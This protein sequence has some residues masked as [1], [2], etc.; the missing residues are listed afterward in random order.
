MALPVL[1]RQIFRITLALFDHKKGGSTVKRLNI[2]VGKGIAV[3]AVMALFVFG[4]GLDATAKQY[5]RLYTGVRPLG[6]GDAF[7]AVADDEN[8]LFYNPAGLSRLSTVQIGLINPLVEVSKKTIDLVQ[9][10]QD[11]DM[12]DTGEVADLLKEYVGEHQHARVGLFPHVGFNVAGAGVMIGGIGQGTLDVDVR[13]PVWPEAHVDMVLDYGAI[14][15]FGL[16]LPLTG[17]SAGVA[18]KF[19]QRESLS[20]IYTA[21]DI[22]AEDFEDRLEDDLYS[23]SGFSADIGVMYTMG[24]IPFMDANVALVVQN[25]PEMDMGEAK[26]IKTQANLGLSIG[27][28]FSAFGIV[29]ALDYK[30]VSGAFEED[31]DIA[32][33]IHTGVEL[34]FLKFL[35][36]RAGLNQGYVSAG[37]TLDLW[38]LR[39][40]F[41]TYSEEVGAYAGQR[42]DRRYVGQVT[43]G[44]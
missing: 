40:D 5:P 18:L 24:F 4:T 12:D 11:A 2:D 28:S 41:A 3:F 21:T 15:G 42:E 26:D 7:T 44:W 32:K 36:V 37:A 31:E 29:A 13:N 17:L 35:A 27:K 38:V 14:G 1:A 8:A 20:E 22:A 25:V 6:M 16:K 9:D 10:A 39:F 30:D 34:R 19:L 23:G 43:L 33:R